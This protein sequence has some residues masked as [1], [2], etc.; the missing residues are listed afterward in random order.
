MTVFKLFLLNTVT[1]SPKFLLRIVLYKIIKESMKLFFFTKKQSSF[2]LLKGLNLTI[3][4][5]EKQ[6]VERRRYRLAGDCY[7]DPFLTY[8]DLPYSGPYVFA[9]L[10]RSSQPGAA[11]S[12]PPRHPSASRSPNLLTARP[13]LTVLWLVPVSNCVYIISQSSCIQ[14][15]SPRELLTPR[16]AVFSF[17]QMKHPVPQILDQRLC[18]RSICSNCYY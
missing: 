1:W 14:L 2:Y 4:V 7:I 18:Q 11:S 15:V 12:L 8:V 17:I 16:I 3:R 10:M 5:R 13:W 9:S 6:G